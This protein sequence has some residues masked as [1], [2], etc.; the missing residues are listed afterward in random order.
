[1]KALDIGSGSGILTAIMGR[2]VTANEKKGKVIG[3]DY[4][5]ALVDLSVH[6]INKGKERELFQNKSIELRQGDGWKGAGEEGPFDA[7]H[8]GE[9]DDDLY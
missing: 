2:M 3:I 5:K 6:N 8:V 7:I 4:I 9:K 1:M